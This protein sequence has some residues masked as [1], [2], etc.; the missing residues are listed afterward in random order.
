MVNIKFTRIIEKLGGTNKAKKILERLY[1]KYG[2]EKI[3]RFLSGE[4]VDNSMKEFLKQQGIE[5]PLGIKISKHTVKSMLIALN[6]R[7]RIPKHKPMSTIRDKIIDI[8]GGSKKA[9]RILEQ[10]YYYETKEINGRS[11]RISIR[12]IRNILINRFP[13]IRK[14]NPSTKT[15]LKVMQKLGIKRYSVGQRFLKKPFKGSTTTMLYLWSLC[16]GDAW[17]KSS[18]KYIHVELEGKRD[19]ILC[20]AETLSLYHQLCMQVTQQPD[21]IKTK[22]GY[23]KLSLTLD[24]SFDFLLRKPKDIFDNITTESSL[25]AVIAGLIDSEGNLTINI[26][27]YPIIRITMTDVVLRD[28]IIE[29]LKKF[30]IQYSLG[31][32][33]KVGTNILNGRYQQQKDA[34]RIRI[35]INKKNQEFL[36]K[37]LK[38]IRHREKKQKLK[39]FMQKITKKL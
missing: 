14:L 29:K 36:N 25:A 1:Q 31:L 15:I 26:F 21:L 27:G 2:L 5:V 9:K 37:V 33:S 34:W 38:F 4:F 11:T 32:Q 16:Y 23:Y 12:D 6:I 8:L 19:T 39:K 18:A 22:R 17:V 10:I 7:M 35:F 24:R 13:E 30:R 20:L 28:L 3:A